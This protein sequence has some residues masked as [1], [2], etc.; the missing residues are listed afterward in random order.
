MFLLEETKFY[1]QE[2]KSQT[3]FVATQ[4]HFYDNSVMVLLIIILSV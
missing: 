1:K 3:I 4:T 2:K